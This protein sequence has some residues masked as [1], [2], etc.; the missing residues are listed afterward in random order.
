[1]IQP[2][3]VNVNII[4]QQLWMGFGEILQASAC[5]DREVIHFGTDG[6]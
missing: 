3:S 6:S 5:R 4:T 2:M 1:M